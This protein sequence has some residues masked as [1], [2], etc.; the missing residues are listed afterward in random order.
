MLKPTMHI[1]LKSVRMGSQPPT[2]ILQQLWEDDRTL[3][4]E[5]KDVPVDNIEEKRETMPTLGKQELDEQTPC[6]AV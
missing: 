6:G 4:K 3:A 1:K 5:W 2:K